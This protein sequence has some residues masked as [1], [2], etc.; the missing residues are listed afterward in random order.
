MNLRNNHVLN[1]Y[2]SNT[3]SFSQLAASFSVRANSIANEIRAIIADITTKS[4]ITIFRTNQ[5]TDKEFIELPER[6]YCSSMTGN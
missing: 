4:T 1:V 5:C 3:C 6:A 2:I